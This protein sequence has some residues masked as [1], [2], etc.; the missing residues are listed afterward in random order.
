M[1]D[2]AGCPYMAKKRRVSNGGG[3]A[4]D[5]K[6]GSATE[7]GAVYYHSYL[8]LERILESQDP[9]SRQLGDEK[10]EEM[11]FII[12]H[13][14]YD[15][16]VLCPTI[17]DAAVTTTS[18]TNTDTAHSATAVAATQPSSPTSSTHAPNTPTSTCSRV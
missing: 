15:P 5:A 9:I 3:R 18:N 17:R 14:T 11:L 12:T 1:N 8:Q 16:H 7:N 4:E 13:Q 10:H 2:A 6:E